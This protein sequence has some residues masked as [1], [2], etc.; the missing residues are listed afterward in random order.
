[1]FAPAES[2]CTILALVFLFRC[3]RAGLSRRGICARG[4]SWNVGCHGVLSLV[5]SCAQPPEQISQILLPR[6][7][8]WLKSNEM[9]VGGLRPSH[10]G[11]RQHA[12]KRSP[13]RGDWD[14]RYRRI[15]Q[16]PIDLHVTRDKR[17]LQIILHCTPALRRTV[18]TP[19]LM[20]RCSADAQHDAGWKRGW[21]RRDRGVLRNCPSLGLIARFHASGQ[22]PPR[23]YYCLPL[24]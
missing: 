3:T 10:N 1:V 13:S 8:R 22:V 17:L 15:Q 21:R 11:L 9:D 12:Q 20:V 24:G 7:S 16:W 6:T 4:S 2:T 14:Y 18:T 23:H 19:M 5:R